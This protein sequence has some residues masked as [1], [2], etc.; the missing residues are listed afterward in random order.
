MT[1]HQQAEQPSRMDAT[2]QPDV[3]RLSAAQLSE[4][5]AAAMN[6][7]TNRPDAQIMARMWLYLA[8]CG[9]SEAIA[10]VDEILTHRSRAA[11]RATGC[12]GS[13]G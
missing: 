2:G 8:A 7:M 6:Y 11:A 12:D 13:G 9:P 1:G 10:M 3:R 5:R 4:I